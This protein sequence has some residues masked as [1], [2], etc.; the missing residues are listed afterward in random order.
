[1]RY[2][3]RPDIL[4]VTGK[5][6][7]FETPET[8]AFGIDE[9]AHALSHVCRFAGHTY[10]FYS[11]AQH[12]VL[13]S[14]VVPPEHALAG[15]LHDAAEAFLGD[16]TRPLKQL[17]PDYKAI[18]KRVEVAV[19]ARFGLADLPPCV[20]VADLIL[21]ATEQRDLMPPHDDAWASIKGVTPLVER[22]SPMNPQQAKEAFIDRYF[23]IVGAR[24]LAAPDDQEWLS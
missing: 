16:V 21:L 3:I 10:R 1:M 7:N 12:C 11:V 5:Y 13:V 17:L 20:K 9:V 6:F 19:L 23:E 18:E 22:I 2:S 14:L 4:T 15:L 8:S 24:L